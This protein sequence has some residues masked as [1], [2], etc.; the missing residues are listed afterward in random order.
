MKASS[1]ETIGVLL[2]LVGLVLFLV[3]FLVVYPAL[4]DPVGTYDRWF[5]E[6][7][8]PAAE[9]EPVA[10]EEETP[11]E[12]V[13][14]F[15]W[16]GEAIVDEVP[17]EEVEEG[18]E[19]EERS[20][21]YRVSL[22]DRSEPGDAEVVSWIWELGD[23]REARGA[24][25]N[26]TYEGPGVYPV[27]LSIED[28]NGIV[29]EV[30]GDVEVPEGGVVSGRVEAEETLDLTG[31]ESALEDAVVTLE[32]SIDDTLDSV[33]STTRSSGIVVL[34]ALAAIATTIV[35]WRVTRSGVMLLRPDQRMRLKVKSADMH[36]DI[37]GT[38]IQEALP[39]VSSDAEQGT[40]EELDPRLV[41][42]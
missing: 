22:E 28:G 38:P 35:A 20:A 4:R 39:D 1:P 6:S 17:E 14:A 30:E 19:P 3:I 25:I 2:I 12:P 24:F 33:A 26:R 7:E 5:P 15:R 10:D 27:R 16:V 34:F 11:T 36:V 32:G 18:A 13:A 8:E 29:S 37:A 31:I 41:E 40:D 42:V 23:G 21:I 9:A